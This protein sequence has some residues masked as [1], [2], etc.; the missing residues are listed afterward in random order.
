MSTQMKS[1]HLG[2]GIGGMMQPFVRST[3]SPIALPALIART[4]QPNPNF[5]S[6]FQVKPT[7]ETNNTPPPNP[8]NPVPFRPPYLLAHNQLIPHKFSSA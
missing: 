3:P 7:P 2:V 5:W 6:R 8:F 4:P 1:H